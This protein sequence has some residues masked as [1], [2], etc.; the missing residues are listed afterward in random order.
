MTLEPQ[1]IV[2]ESMKKESFRATFLPP[3]M[4]EAEGPT[5]SGIS[6]EDLLGGRVPNNRDLLDKEG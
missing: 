6:L 1:S 4:N 2:T 5:G 3:P